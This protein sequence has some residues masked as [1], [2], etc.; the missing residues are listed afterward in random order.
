MSDRL[1]YNFRMAMNDLVA[2]IDAEIAKLQEVRKLLA[3]VSVVNA[4][5]AK[6]GRPAKEKVEPVKPKGKKRNMT[7]EGRARIAEAV[8][9]RWAAQKKTAK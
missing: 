3:T 6:R 8:K 7:P 2:L 5:P 4:V 1:L 9:R